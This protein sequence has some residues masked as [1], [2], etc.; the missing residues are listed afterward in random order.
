MTINP[1]VF[2]KEKLISQFWGNSLSDRDAPP[3]DIIFPLDQNVTICFKSRPNVDSHPGFRAEI[4]DEAGKEIC[5][6]CSLD[7]VCLG[8]SEVGVIKSPNYPDFYPGNINQCWVGT[9]R[10]G[11]AVSLEFEFFDVS[12]NEFLNI[13]EQTENPCRFFN[14]NHICKQ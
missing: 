3:A 9:P 8:G 6:L 7:S 11:Y 10:G 13:P 14:F 1:P 12:F 5:Q 2:K 4:S